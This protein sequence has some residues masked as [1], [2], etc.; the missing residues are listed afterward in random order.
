VRLAVP[1][2]PLRPVRPTAPDS[3]A[4]SRAREDQREPG[5]QYRLPRRERV[6]LVF[7]PSGSGRRRL[8][9]AC[10]KL[11]EVPRPDF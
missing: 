9:I 3:V 4:S 6:C 11:P 1:A 8:P 10:R 5:S 7:L 2:V